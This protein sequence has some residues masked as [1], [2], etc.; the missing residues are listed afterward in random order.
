MLQDRFFV[1]AL[2][3]VG[4]TKRYQTI[5]RFFEPIGHYGLHFNMES[6]KFRQ[7]FGSHMYNGVVNPK[8]VFDVTKD[9]QNVEAIQDGV[10]KRLAQLFS[11]YRRTLPPADLAER[12]FNQLIKCKLQGHKVVKDIQG[13]HALARL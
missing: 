13:K 9:P 1:D 12:T 8:A 5:F 11:K 7:T 6:T 4:F 10:Q 3:T 2:A